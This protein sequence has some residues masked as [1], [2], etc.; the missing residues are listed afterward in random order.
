MTNQN[1]ELAA[2]AL[3]ALGVFLLFFMLGYVFS[4][5]EAMEKCLQKHSSQ[6]CIN[7]LR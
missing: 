6:V 3:I 1:K 2:L 4:D 7:I 5:N